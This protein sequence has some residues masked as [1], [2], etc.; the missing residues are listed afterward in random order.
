MSTNV[1]TKE[2]IKRE[3]ITIDAKNQPL[4]RLAS[5]VA[6]I[7]M[8]KTKPQFVP[9][10]DNGDKVVVLNAALVKVTGKKET[11]KTYTRHSGYP[12]GLRVQ[13]LAEV[14]ASKPTELVR[15]AVKGML[16]KN[17]LGKEMLL[18]LEIH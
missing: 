16:P 13:T 10:M 5:Q 2:D 15:H 18:K 7:L 6:Q 8:G 17:R 1:L 9:Y 4:G 11:Q 14:R 12:G 3:V